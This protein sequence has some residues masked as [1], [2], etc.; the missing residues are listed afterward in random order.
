MDNGWVFD[1]ASPGRTVRCAEVGLLRHGIA[2]VGRVRPMAVILH[3]IFT[4][5]D[6]GWRREAACRH[7]DPDLFF[8]AGTTGAAVGQVEAAKAFCESCPVQDACLRFALETN[9]EAGIW[10]GKEEHERRRLRRVWREK[11]RPVPGHLTIE[12][13]P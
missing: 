2:T 12:V 8:P 7:A 13:V 10:G 3:P 1:A 4:W 9:Q 6:G 11:R 5:D